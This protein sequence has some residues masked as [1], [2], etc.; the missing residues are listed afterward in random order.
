[1]AE[2]DLNFISRQLDR[3]LTEIASMRD[4]MQVMMSIQLRTSQ[5][6]IN[7]TQELHNLEAKV[8]RIDTR[9]RKLEGEREELCRAPHASLARGDRSA[10]YIGSLHLRHAR[11]LSEIALVVG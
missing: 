1:V 11:D 3:V 10:Q 6:Q 9:L 8:S 7:L 5:G 4:D 2:P